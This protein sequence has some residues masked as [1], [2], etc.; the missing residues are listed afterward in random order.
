[1]RVKLLLLIFLIAVLATLGCSRTATAS[2][3]NR[4]DGDWQIGVGYQGMLVGDLLHGISARAWYQDRFGLEGN[5]FYGGLETK[6]N[7]DKSTFDAYIGEAKFMYAP[8]I[9]DYSKFYGSVQ[10]T[11]GKIDVPTI[12]DVDDDFYGFGITIGSEWHV[13]EFPEIGFNFD[14]GYKHYFYDD[15]DSDGDKFE[16]RLKGIGV[17]AGIHYYF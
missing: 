5:F 3:S 4:H 6:Y 15:R 11:Y 7:S 9:R 13:K 14:V 16:L 17:T 12:V 2:E 1:M 8:V 10:A